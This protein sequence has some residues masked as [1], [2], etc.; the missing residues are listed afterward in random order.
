MFFLKNNPR[1]NF[2]IIASCHELNYVSKSK[3]KEPRL[4][5]KTSDCIKDIK[6]LNSAI[7]QFVL[8]Y[9]TNVLQKQSRRGV[10]L[11]RCSADMQQIYRRRPMQERDFNKVAMQHF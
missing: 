9:R 2:Y 7:T 5:Q 11:K 3:R 4:S 6:V 10:L 1:R 8:R